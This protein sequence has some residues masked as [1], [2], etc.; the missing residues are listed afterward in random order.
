[1]SNKI[2]KINFVAKRVVQRGILPFGGAIIVVGVVFVG[3]VAIT[4]WYENLSRH[5]QMAI[6]ITAITPFFLIVFTVWLL[7]AYRGLKQALQ[8]AEEECE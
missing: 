6:K 4:M 2:C 3:V 1:M 8:D 7:S 5:W